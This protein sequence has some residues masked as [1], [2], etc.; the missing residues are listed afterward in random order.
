MLKISK[1][2]LEEA[3]LGITALKPVLQMQVKVANKNKKQGE[4]DSKQLGE[5]FDTAINAMVTLL[6]Y[7]DKH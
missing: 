3:I 1:E 2:D 4:F 6:A 7:M 5:H